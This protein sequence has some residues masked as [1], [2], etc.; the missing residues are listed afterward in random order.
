MC[1][2]TR[3]VPWS[4][5]S[6]SK[7][8]GESILKSASQIE[9]L[10]EHFFTLRQALWIIPFYFAIWFVVSTPLQAES[11]LSNW[12]HDSRLVV[13]ND[14]T[15][16]LDRAWKGDISVVQFWI[17]ALPSNLAAEITAERLTAEAASSP[18]QR[19][20]SRTLTP[21]RIRMDFFPS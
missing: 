8:V 5:I 1:L 17:R 7:L 20:R 14:A 16:H 2:R 10:F 4:V 6:Y 11:R 9:T 12:I 19:I 15:G 18:S 3:P 21:L 13:G